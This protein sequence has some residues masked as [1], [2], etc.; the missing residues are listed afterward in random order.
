MSSDALV[1]QELKSLQAELSAGQRARV[2]PAPAVAPAA[3][4]GRPTLKPAEPADD[5]G[6]EEALGYLRELTV[7]ATRFFEEAEK[8]IATH[9]TESVVGA[10]LIGIVIGRFLGR[11]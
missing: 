6:Q 2:T 5:A 1:S 3:D 11:R 10:L 7:E 8:N 9:P 4:G